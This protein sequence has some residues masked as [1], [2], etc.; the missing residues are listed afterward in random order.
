MKAN[1]KTYDAVVVGGGPAGATAALMLARAGL[2]VRLLE[3]ARFPRFHIGESFLPANL[4]LIRELGL[5]PALR[6]LPQVDK[7][8]VEFVVG[9]GRS[10]QHFLFADCLLRESNETFNIERAPFDAMLLA[11]AAAAG[12]E[13]S[14]N[15][16][17]R[18]IVRLAQG[19]VAVEADHLPGDEGPTARES[20][21]RSE[22]ISARV[23]IDASGQA[24]LVGKHLG[25]RRMLP[26]HRKIAYFQHF[27]G[28]ERRPGATAGDPTMVMCDEGWFWII[29][30]DE[31]RDSIGL[32]MDVD[33]A[34][35]VGVPAD[36]MLEWGI[37]RCPLLR[38]RTAAAA[39]PPTNV[40]CAD[41]SYRCRPYSGP[42]YFLVGDAATFLDPIFS[43]GVC[44]GM[45]AGV[46]A[47]RGIVAMLRE[48]ASP[49][50]VRRSY[51]RYLAGS[52]TPLFRMVRNYYRHSFRELFLSGSGPLAVHNATLSVLAGSVFPR[53]VFPLRWRLELFF[54][55]VRANRYLPL[56]PRRE[57]FS[58]FSAEAAATAAGLA[59]TAPAGPPGQHAG[60][61]GLAE[62]PATAQGPIAE[63]VPPAG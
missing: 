29:P 37:A 44:L 7:R 34:R 54:L 50:R 23:L 11:E 55:M 43:T 10:N 58:L 51:N 33:A 16:A 39:S 22:V 8:G 2:A 18:R 60:A 52:S 48:G 42:G 4:Q 25:I 57:P 27:E 26:E 46:E 21:E 36:R 56:A 49:R 62:P 9:H 41:F 28:V 59:A 6:R 12:A 63:T 32:V 15:T 53:L 5:E 14:Q 17:V 30:I 31:R 1:E 13:V 61:A 45:M 47:A 38:R 19:D 20:V 3:R 40:V 24:T 35:R